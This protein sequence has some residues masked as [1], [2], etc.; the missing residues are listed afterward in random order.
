MRWVRA[1][2]ILALLLAGCA[3]DA[4]K[5]IGTWQSTDP[6]N[7]ESF[8]KFTPD[9]TFAMLTRPKVVA[10][11]GMVVAPRPGVETRGTYKTEAGV[12]YMQGQGLDA[13]L[14]QLKIATLTDTVLILETA[15]GN[16]VIYSYQRI[17][18]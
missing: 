4:R 17:A 12:L 5:I 11:P 18:P 15:T 8:L 10:P 6:T 3:S 14:T 13:N 9:G 7:F 16:I 1:T 2:P